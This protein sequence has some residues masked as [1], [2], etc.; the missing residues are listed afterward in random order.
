MNPR[1]HFTLCR[2]ERCMKMDQSCKNSCRSSLR[3]NFSSVSFRLNNRLMGLGVGS[4]ETTIAMQ[5]IDQAHECQRLIGDTQSP[6]ARSALPRTSFAS[7]LG[8]YFITFDR[9]ISAFARRGQAILAGTSTSKSS[10]SG[11]KSRGKNPSICQGSPRRLPI[12]RR[13]PL[14]GTW[15]MASP[16]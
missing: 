11:T 7:P 10:L 14:P 16:R 13:F 15:Q 3:V 2:D 4:C 5:L 8:E 12:R 9:R 1:R 6:K